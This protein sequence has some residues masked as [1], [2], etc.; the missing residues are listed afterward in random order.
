MDLIWSQRNLG[1]LCKGHTPHELVFVIVDAIVPDEVKDLISKCSPSL[2][3][4]YHYLEVH[5]GLDSDGRAFVICNWL[6]NGKSSL[7]RRWLF[8]K[9]VA[10][11]RKVFG[12]KKWLVHLPGNV[13]PIQIA[14]AEDLYFQGVK[15]FGDHHELESV[16]IA[17]VGLGSSRDM[18]RFAGLKGYRKWINENPD[19]L[20]S[21][22]I[23]ARLSGFARE[24]GCD[25]TVLKSSE[26]R[27]ERCN[28][29]L[30][31]GG[32][33]DISPPR[34][35]TVSKN[36]KKGEKPL[37][38]IGKGI[39]FDTGG[40]N[41][42]PFDSFV[43]CMKND[44]GGAA[45]MA[46]LFMSLVRAGYKK[47]IVLVIPACENLVAQGSMKPGVVVKS[48]AGK[49][50][51]IEHTDAEGRLI[52]ADAIDYACENFDPGKIWVA[53]TL[54]T[55]ALRQFTGYFTPVHF[56]DQSLT[57][58]LE[59][60]SQSWGEGFRFWDEFLP[61]S[62]GNNTAAGDI[63]NMGRLPGKASIGGGSSVAAHFLKSFSD[64]PLVHFDIFASAWNW[65]GDYPGAGYGA[66]GAPFNSLFNF[67]WESA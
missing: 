33:S 27:E 14:M 40:I 12:L 51:F 42:K 35:M 55:A 3:K 38:L 58:G 17:G 19:D 20:T 6:E 4:R 9:A 66:T 39:T 11:V 64:V 45:L 53:A 32:A 31:V 2:Y 24:Q 49:E 65:S 25:Y 21:K 29:L 13:T 5:K 63:T 52:L 34:L 56:G 1:S 30:A 54:T 43:N 7:E 16:E 28:L 46:N 26:L 47:P 8:R 23:D 36:L 41:V 57:E 61:F 22:E 62:D 44:M 37:V 67:L 59:R 18:T 10:G 60:V 48:R 50:V 15:P